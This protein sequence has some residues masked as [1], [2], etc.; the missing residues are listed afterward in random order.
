MTKKTGGQLGPSPPF[1]FSKLS[2]QNFEIAV[3]FSAVERPNNNA[4]GDKM[5][6][7]SPWGMASY[8]ISPLFTYSICYWEIR[9]HLSGGGEFSDGEIFYGKKFP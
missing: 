3:L 7:H 2:D 5:T 6:S 1:Y 9:L 4:F 8:N